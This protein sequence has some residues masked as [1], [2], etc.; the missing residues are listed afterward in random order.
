MRA[1][2]LGARGRARLGSSPEGSAR[3]AGLRKPWGRTCAGPLSGA[4]LGSRP[5]GAAAAAAAAA[6]EGAARQLAVSA[7]RRRDSGAGPGEHPPGPHGLFLRPLSCGP[8]RVP[9]ARPDSGLVLSS[10]GLSARAPLESRYG[11]R[12][13]TRGADRFPAAPPGQAAGGPEWTPCPGSAVQEG[14]GPSWEAGFCRGGCRRGR[15]A[16]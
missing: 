12:G 9:R 6:W 16:P 15:G 4:G 2:R 1:R 13:A 8:P 11:V 10:A 3:V 7:P 14:G 5:R